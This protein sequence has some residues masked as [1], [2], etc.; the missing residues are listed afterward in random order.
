M[1]LIVR[2]ITVT[3]LCVCVTSDS[4]GSEFSGRYRDAIEARADLAVVPEKNVKEHFVL[5]RLG[6]LVVVNINE[7]SE[8]RSFKTATSSAKLQKQGA[9]FVVEDITTN[10]YGTTDGGII[11]HAES[12]EVFEAVVTDSGLILK[13]RFKGIAAG[14]LFSDDPRDWQKAIE[15]LNNDDRVLSAELNVN[16]Y[17]RKPT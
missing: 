3:L 2:S 8:D 17:D 7:I 5:D 11:V 16:F 15:L 13:H 1:N 12:N 14:V 10:R 6:G 9:L 4:F